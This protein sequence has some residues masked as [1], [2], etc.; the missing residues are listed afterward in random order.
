LSYIKNIYDM[1]TVGVSVV[2]W[3]ALLVASQ[4]LWILSAI[5]LI[6]L[7]VIIADIAVKVVQDLTN[8]EVIKDI[9]GKAV[10]IT[11]CDTGFGKLLA[12][13]LD[14]LG[15]KVYAC[16]LYPEEDG[17]RSLQESATNGLKVVK[18]D[19]TNDDDVAQATTLLKQDLGDDKLWCVVNNSGIAE[20]SEVELC[21]ISR[22]QQ[23]LDVNTLGPLRVTKAFLPLLRNAR[24][25]R[26]II[27]ASLAGRFT[28]PGFSAYSMSKH[29][30]VSLAD[31]LRQEL[32]KWNISVHTIEPALYKTSISNPSINI[33][34]TNRSWEA[35]PEEI[36]RSYG[37]AY[38]EDFRNYIITSAANGKPHEKLH[39]VVD[40]MVHAV[41]SVNPKDRY[42]PSMLTQFRARVLAS[43]PGEVL[44]LLL[45]SNLPKT[46]PADLVE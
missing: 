45:S 38:I 37:E 39:E 25:G 6:V 26:V 20:I 46:L 35:T 11:G 31:G 34:S 18:M 30:A 10:L 41:T 28:F 13:H 44:S 9:K 14:R 29:A 16:C 22:Y 1:S 24:Q 36:R 43:L 40:D 21:P 32:V 17:A 8:T 19:V 2:L 4:S 12:E 3:A 5:G 27:V 15:F 33:A 42:V 23:V 7:S